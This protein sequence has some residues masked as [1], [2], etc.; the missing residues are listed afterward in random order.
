MEK[1]ILFMLVAV[2]V[3]IGGFS[4]C[5][6]EDNPINNEINPADVVGTWYTEYDQEGVHGQGENAVEYSKV[7]F[8]G[9]LYEGGTGFCMCLLVDANGDV[10]DL[11]DEFLGA[12]CDYTIT[13]DRIDI[14]LT[15]SSAAVTLAPNWSMTYR[16]GQLEG[17]IRDGLECQLS[18]ITEAQEARF[19][20]WMRQLGL[21]YDDTPDEPEDSQ[22]IDLSTITEGYYVAKDGD[23]LTGTLH[24]Y[25]NGGHGHFV[26]C[27]VV[28]PDGASIT[29][30]NVTIGGPE[31][32]EQ[33]NRDTSPAINCL[34]N[35]I[36]RLEGNNEVSGIYWDLPCIYVKP[37][38]TLTF[39][40]SSDALSRGEMPYLKVNNEGRDGSGIGGGTKDSGEYHDCGNICFMRCKVEAEC[41][42]EAVA[43][44][45]CAG[46][47]C[48]Y[49]RFEDQCHVSAWGHWNGFAIGCG[50]G[51]YCDDIIILEGSTVNA[52]GGW[53]GGPAIGAMG[54]GY[55][56]RVIMEGSTVT[57]N[58]GSASSDPMPINAWI[59]ADMIQLNRR[60][61]KN[62]SGYMLEDGLDVKS[63][64]GIP[65]MKRN[66]TELYI[67]GL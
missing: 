40:P 48:G 24:F 1:K 67:K 5:I 19:Q 61:A 49:I 62:F 55:C 38:K 25:H 41:L 28:I 20:N 15:G 53:Q 63:K 8:Y 58:I 22:V 13:G 52:N 26:D 2:C 60:L 36:I 7:V 66:G 37:Y 31:F 14:T 3:M 33:D 56:R 21:G 34:G 59:N 45:S 17:K 29:L 4:S 9:S 39:A 18:R 6:A 57:A 42:G 46:G 27:H 11:I 65:A 16:N 30:R 50:N 32:L 43:I 44:G 51:G 12:G 23:I 54:D 10:I 47:K 64:G 35:A